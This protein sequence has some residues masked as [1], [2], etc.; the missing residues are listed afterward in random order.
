MQENVMPNMNKAQNLM[1]RK[2]RIIFR[3]SPSPVAMTGQSSFTSRTAP[4]PP[5]AARA[6][7]C[8]LFAHVKMRLGPEK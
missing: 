3:L 5:A 8:Y 6:P 7:F 4:P 1:Q 2:T